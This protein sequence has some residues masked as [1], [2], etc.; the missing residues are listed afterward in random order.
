MGAKWHGGT[1]P[2]VARTQV[3]NIMEQ[4]RE[5]GGRV[6]Q[7]RRMV[8]EKILDSGDHHVTAPEL[9]EAMRGVDSE[10]HES[11]VYRV[12]E[13]LTDLRVLEPVQVQAGPTV[14]HLTDK[15]HIH[16]HLL[17]SECGSV[18]Q[19][20]GTLL[21]DVARQVARHHGFAMRVD[22]PAT[23]L[24]RCADCTAEL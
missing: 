16:H 19:T 13:R 2:F 10:F 7:S 5:S 20:D 18:T 22:S 15:A 11:T 23:L 14:F 12:L 21:D 9:I 8:V 1:L 4:I 24:G 6:T 3:E 17:C